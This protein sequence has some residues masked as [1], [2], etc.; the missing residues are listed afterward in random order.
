MEGF[1]TGALKIFPNASSSKFF[2]IGNGTVIRDFTDFSSSPGLNQF[3]TASYKTG[4][5]QDEG[6]NLYNGLPLITSDNKLIQNYA[7]EGY[8]EIN[9]TNNDY[10]STINNTP[11]EI[12]IHMNNISNALLF[13]SESEFENVRIIKSAGSN[14][15]N[16]H[17][18]SWTF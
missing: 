12:S 13:T 2:P 9:P 17:H 1:I 3:I 6:E 10:E 5:P 7:E 16:L 4:I 15:P 11:Y 18:N 14:D 8:W